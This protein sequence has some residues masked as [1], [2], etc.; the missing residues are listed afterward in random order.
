VNSAGKYKPKKVKSGPN[1]TQGERFKKASKLQWT[2]LALRNKH[3]EI[4]I[5]KQ[6]GDRYGFAA[7]L[8]NLADANHFEPT[9]VVLTT[10][11]PQ[12]A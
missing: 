11:L 8:K 3:R 10:S 12:M 6:A 9:Y 5:A 7:A 1:E 4:S 2:L